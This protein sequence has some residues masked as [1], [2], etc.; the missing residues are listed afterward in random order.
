MVVGALRHTERD[1]AAGSTLRAGGDP[2][3]VVPVSRGVYR[4]HGGVQLGQHATEDHR[5]DRA[6]TVRLS[7]RQLRCV[8]A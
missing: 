5:D 2:S 7:A 4:R 3:G 8:E 1:C 6:R